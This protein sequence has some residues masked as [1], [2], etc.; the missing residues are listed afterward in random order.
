MANAPADII[1][2]YIAA[3]RQY[4]PPR[5]RDEVTA[6]IEQELR[7]QVRATEAHTGR[8]MTEDELAALVRMRGHPY[9]LAQPYRTGRYL[10]IG[11]SVLPQYWHALRTTLTIAFLVIVVLAGVLA[12]GGQSPVALANYVSVYLRL[13]FYLV[14]VVSIA[15]A[16]IDIVQG[17][18]LLKKQ[19]DPR[20]AGTPAVEA[21]PS[22]AGGSLADVATSGVFMVWWLMVPHYPWVLLGPGARYFDFSDGWRAAYG[23]VT[24]C[25]ALSLLVHFLAIVRRPWT[26]LARWRTVIANGASILGAGILLGAGTLLV[27]S[28]DSRFDAPTLALVDRA[29]RWCLV[30]TMIV[31]AVQAVRDAFR[32]WRRSAQTS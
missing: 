27:P 25:F 23:P 8:P 15:F 21:S 19:W 32:A 24:A 17:R 20:E 16:V 12:A 2:R 11:P 6:P 22:G 26:W 31:A 18:L 4:L 14:I 7:A 29:I 10:L 1:G 9:V 3:I 5:S 13:A 30:W 28:A